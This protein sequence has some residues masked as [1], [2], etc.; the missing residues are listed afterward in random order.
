[1]G[2]QQEGEV[3]V[4]IV[5]WS[6]IY[7]YDDLNFLLQLMLLTFIGL[8]YKSEIQ[9]NSGRKST[10][11]HSDPHS[12]YRIQSQKQQTTSRECSSGIPNLM[13]LVH[14]CTSNLPLSMQCRSFLEN[15]F[16]SW[17]LIVRWA[18]LDIFHQLDQRIQNMQENFNSLGT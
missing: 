8:T 12:A 1:M 7:K 5:V 6:C 17:S 2:N 15:Q 16:Q 4:H 14:C 13:H 18:F 10:L 9:K 11:L 3:Q